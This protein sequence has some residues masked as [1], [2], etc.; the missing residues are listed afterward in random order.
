MASKSPEEV[1][2]LASIRSLPSVN[3]MAHFAA[4][5]FNKLNKKLTLAGQLSLLSVSISH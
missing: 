4:N 1:L 2:I 3:G 5:L